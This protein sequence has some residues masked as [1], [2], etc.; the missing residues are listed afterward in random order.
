MEDL[1]DG[2]EESKYIITT[3]GELF[4]M[5]PGI[6]LTRELFVASLDILVRLVP[7]D[8]PDSG[9]EVVKF[10]WMMLHVRGVKVL[11]SIVCTV[12]GAPITAATAKM[13]L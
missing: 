6:Y 7:Q 8:L 5:I 9:P 12:D 3:S 4:V 1:E 13:H 2:K 11:F 10:G